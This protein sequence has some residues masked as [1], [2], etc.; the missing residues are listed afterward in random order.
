[1]NGVPRESTLDPLLF[2]LYIND[3]ESSLYFISNINILNNINVTIY[4][5]DTAITI[6]DTHI[7]IFKS[8]INNY[9]NYI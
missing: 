4:A 2:A 6:S 9:I 1:M 8:N 5:N 7:N 3:T